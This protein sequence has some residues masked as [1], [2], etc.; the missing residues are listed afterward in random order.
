MGSDTIQATPAHSTGSPARVEFLHILQM[1][2]TVF[3]RMG[4]NTD[5]MQHHYFR[6]DIPML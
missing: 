5:F 6:H 2:G 1:A 4:V 3:P